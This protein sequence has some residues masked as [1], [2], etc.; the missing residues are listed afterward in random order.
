M[1][2]NLKTLVIAIGGTGT[3]IA[4]LLT[5]R[6]ENR[7]PT[8]V[9][10]VVVD[11]HTGGPEARVPTMAYS[12]SE[13]IDYPAEWS[14]L[15]SDGRSALS[16]WWPSRVLPQKLVGFDE[17]CG[18]IR[19]NG[20]FF[21]MRHADYI[22]ESIETGI[23]K[24]SEARRLGLDGQYAPIQWEVYVLC[25]LGNG[26]GGGAFM[27]VA[28]IAKDILL[29]RGFTNP[30]VTGVFIPGSVT[31]NGSRGR[32][33]DVMENRVA[34]SGFASLVELQYEFNRDS[35]Y[36]FRP[37]KP[38][39]FIGWSGSTYREFEP[40]RG[41]ESQEQAATQGQPFDFAFVLDVANKRAVLNNYHDLLEAGAE[42]LVALIGGADADSRLLDLRVLCEDG[43]RFCSFGS[44]A[45]EA[46]TAQLVQYCA[47]KLS[48]QALA[49]AGNERGIKPDIDADLL[50]DR[51]PGGAERLDAREITL[52]KSADFFLDKVLN[53]KEG[54]ANPEQMNDVFAQFDTVDSDLRVAFRSIQGDRGLSKLERSQM[55]DKAHQ[56][57]SY[58][59]S[60]AQDLPRQREAQMKALWERVPGSNVRCYGD[61]KKL[62]QAGT[63]WLLEQR[64]GAFVERG[65]FGPL[66]QWLTELRRLVKD[67]S[68]S[69][70]RVEVKQHLSGADQLGREL[71]LKDLNRVIEEL[72]AK[73]GS[74]FAAFQGSAI[75]TKAT[76][77]GREAESAFDFL[78]WQSEIVAVLRFY[79]W[80]DSHIGLLLGGARKAASLVD[81]EG[82]RGG[83]TTKITAIEQALG[84]RSNGG[85][86]VYVGCDDVIRAGLIDALQQDPD[87]S[88]RGMLQHLS[89]LMWEVY[90]MSLDQDC[91]QVG[92]VV[93]S[94]GEEGIEALRGQAVSRLKGTLSV[95]LLQKVEDRIKLSVANMADIDELLVR[96]ARAKIQAWYDL[97]FLPSQQGLPL[98]YKAQDA[99]RALEAVVHQGGIKG[100]QQQFV[101]YPDF[102]VAMYRR[103][104]GQVSGAVMDFIMARVHNLA[105][106][107]LPLWNPQLPPD[108]RSLIQR[109]AFFNYS[110]SA[111]HLAQALEE[112][113][114]AGLIKAQADEFFPRS[115][116]ECVSVALGA[117]LEHLAHGS[118]VK[119]YRLAMQGLPGTPPQEPYRSWYAS[120]NP[121]TTLAYEQAGL[122]W[123]EQHDQQHKVTSVLGDREGELVLALAEFGTD[124]YPELFRYISHNGA[125]Y[126]LQREIDPAQVEEASAAF[127]DYGVGI[128][129]GERIGP[130]GVA[131]VTDWLEGKDRK[132]HKGVEGL[133]LRQDLKQLLWSDLEKMMMGY[134]NDN[135]QVVGLGVESAVKM[136]RARGKALRASKGETPDAACKRAQ[137][138]ALLILA[139]QLL[140]SG[141]R[142][143][144]L[145]A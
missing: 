126:Y 140:P 119:S 20:R 70:Y 28:A 41:I 48:L 55:V 132:A 59:L 10:I 105:G 68:D 56:L 86:V 30:L 36:A 87:T 58:L 75:A 62:E 52:E 54:G 63:R 90:G 142:P 121:H 67:S 7:P 42:A 83:L 128:A 43:R 95:S 134:W 9:S 94:L 82:I 64:V 14:R 27:D 135:K 115:R 4:K 40:A 110:T 114:N 21:V 104:D 38:Y 50:V 106:A 13:Q 12:S 47:A 71:D 60:K 77:V 107:A 85:K 81:D 78:L 99:K 109:K 37:D 103:R 133:A 22:V 138:D 46:P 23:A 120:F 3:K 32:D 130:K 66:V 11:A 136:I 100:L 19:A 44:M 102:E 79:T 61:L 35:R 89:S 18:A 91:E 8:D 113:D 96:E 69:I 97:Y 80:L 65:A 117:R 144:F 125:L 51:L 131:H 39:S 1:P 53:V 73:A 26:T 25:S 49:W 118:E 111:A 16:S 29:G 88:S 116:L 112:L 139:K 129:T 143:A 57:R 5:D 92:V 33:Q 6:W 84:R 93:N 2:S 122:R 145:K 123:L 15:N 141:A 17:G 127:S 24:L 72:K 101:D 76:M 98:D 137:G 108:Q 34:A 45:L 31:R 124:L 74:I